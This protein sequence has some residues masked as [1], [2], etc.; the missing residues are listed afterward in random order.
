MPLIRHKNK[1]FVLQWKPEW[2]L[3]LLVC[4]LLFRYGRIKGDKPVRPFVNWRKAERQ[5]FLRGLP[6]Y[7]TRQELSHRVTYLCQLKYNPKGFRQ[8]R[9]YNKTHRSFKVIQN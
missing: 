8:K 3:Q 5:G 2:D 7:L 6:K 1:V 4:A 9:E